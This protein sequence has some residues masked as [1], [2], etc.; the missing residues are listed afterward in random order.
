M[1]KAFKLCP[2][3][4]SGISDSTYVL[5]SP[6]TFL[7][8]VHRIENLDAK[9]NDLVELPKDIWKMSGLNRIDVTDNLLTGETTSH[10]Y[11]VLE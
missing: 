6:K 10:C 5:C 3:Y 9:G 7:P 4:W 11:V 1:V 8:F 2:S